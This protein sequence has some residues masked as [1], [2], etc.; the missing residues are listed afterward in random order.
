MKLYKLFENIILRE[1]GEPLTGNVS[2]EDVIDA[3]N[4]KY[5]VNI[6]YDDYP[7]ENPSVT[8]SKRYIQVYNF[9]DTTANNKAIRAYQTGGGSKTTPGRGAWK[10]FRLDRIRSW[11]PTKM[12][13]YSPVDKFNPNGDRT[14]KTVHNIATFDD[15]YKTSKYQRKSTDFTSKDIADMSPEEFEKQYGRIQASREKH[16]VSRPNKP[17]YTAQG[18]EDTGV[19]YQATANDIAK[20]KNMADVDVFD[21]RKALAKSGGDFDAAINWLN[22]QGFRVKKNS[23]YDASDD[24]YFDGEKQ[25][26]QDKLDAERKELE[27]KQAYLAKKEKEYQDRLTK[28]KFEREKQAE[29]F[30]QQ[31]LQKRLQQ[32]LA[33]KNNKNLKTKTNDNTATSRPQ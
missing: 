13:F 31:E 16:R 27:D 5:F 25:E 10:I 6:T 9:S 32:K 30:K 26:Y 19:N 21:A 33:N 22:S 17:A 7:D 29:K 11:Q 12:K 8:P 4:G 23:S 3:I 18:P 24:E 14:M 15:K 1:V 28:N 2:D 20:L